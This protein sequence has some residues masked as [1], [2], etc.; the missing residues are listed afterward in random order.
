M[1]ACDTT[2]FGGDIDY[3]AD[4]FACAGERFSNAADI[5]SNPTATGLDPMI[6]V[7]IAVGVF[8]L[9]AFRSSRS[10]GGAK[11]SGR[12]SGGIPLPVYVIGAA[13]AYVFVSGGL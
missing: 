12:S 7:V 2:D 5:A 11:A 8:L 10:G 4:W 1:S 13:V 9:L 3:G 6:A